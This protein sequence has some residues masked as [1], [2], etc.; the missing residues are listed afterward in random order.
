MGS[1]CANGHPVDR[2]SLH[3]RFPKNASSTSSSTAAEATAEGISQT[4]TVSPRRPLRTRSA[5]SQELI[6]E[7]HSPSCSRASAIPVGN[8]QLLSRALDLTEI[9]QGPGFETRF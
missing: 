1:R 9:L 6:D 3:R 4:G 5:T 7:T 8:D 2:R